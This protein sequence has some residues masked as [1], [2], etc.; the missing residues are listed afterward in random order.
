MVR[1]AGKVLIQNFIYF[2]FYIF[3]ETRNEAE[4]KVLSKRTSIPTQKSSSTKVSDVE[5]LEKQKRRIK[6]ANDKK[7]KNQA[8]QTNSTYLMDEVSTQKSL[9]ATPSDDGIEA[10]PVPSSNSQQIH[11]LPQSMFTSPSDDVT[12]ETY[13]VSPSSPNEM[14]INENDY[15]ITPGRNIILDKSDQCTATQIRQFAEKVFKAGSQI[16]KDGEKF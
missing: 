5:L 1:S 4:E 14:I 13:D 9:F 2:W 6:K 3:K 7:I 15:P 11:L 10:L 12:Y 16:G 8:K